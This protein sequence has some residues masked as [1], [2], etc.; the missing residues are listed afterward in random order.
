M[1]FSRRPVISERKQENIFPVL[2]LR[3]R[4]GMDLQNK[5]VRE[6]HVYHIG[7]KVCF[8]IISTFIRHNGRISDTDSTY[9]QTKK[10]KCG[11]MHYTSLTPDKEL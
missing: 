8:G 9:K 11:D 7:S 2:D 1:Y 10:F 3:D 6:P 4:K 5:F